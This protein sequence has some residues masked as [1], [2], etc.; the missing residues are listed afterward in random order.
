MTNVNSTGAKS[1]RANSTGVNST[2]VNS[3]GAALAADNELHIL[4]LYPD[5]LDLH[6]GRGDIMGL[7]HTARLLGLTP[8][9]RRVDGFDQEPDFAWAD[10]IWLGP[11]EVRCAD[12]VA[13]QLTPWLPRL[14]AALERGALLAAVDSTGAAVARETFRLDG[15]SFPGLGLLD[16]TCR[17]MEQVVGN[18][19]WFAL[20]DGEE[21]MGI[22]I[23]LLKIELGARAQPLGRV[24]Y[25][26]GNDGAGGEGARQGSVVFT[27]ALGPICVKNPRFAARLIC[28][29][30]AAKCPQLKPEI[31]AELTRVEDMSFDL[32]RTFIQK[33]QAG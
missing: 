5:V 33:K 22:Q 26:Y 12:V 10:L 24:V 25:G 27:N 31:P 3:T 20:P 13:R 11:G 21:V 16:M 1:T 30:L 19:L 15:S 14:Q 8:V 4:W 23:S 6:G 18:D 7:E 32:I 9:T 28:Q 2:G 29:A 17:E